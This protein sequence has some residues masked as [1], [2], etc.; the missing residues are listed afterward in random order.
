MSMNDNRENN[1]PKDKIKKRYIKTPLVVALC[2]IVG[3]FGGILGSG[4][5]NQIFLKPSSTNNSSSDSASYKN[6]NSST[7]L[8]SAQVVKLVAD[9]VVDIATESP[10]KTS[11]NKSYVSISAGSGVIYSSDGYIITNEHIVSNNK[12][13]VTLRNGTSYSATLIGSDSNNDIA[14][15][16]I[17]ANNLSAVTFG[18]SSSIEVGEE[19]TVIGNPL[20]ELGGT[21]T[22]GVVSAINR[23][24]EIDGRQMSLIQTS[25]EINSGNSGGGV[26]RRTGE[27]IGI[28][29]A[30]SSG[31]DIEG[32]GF[33]IPSNT[34]KTVVKN[35]LK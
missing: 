32:L 3:I 27:L 1:S 35:L 2:L 5:Y 11:G 15:L 24:V 28:V 10:A 7:L 8:S 29:I 14:L 23:P 30:K 31:N 17:N 20:G 34:V 9:S 12:I 21:V 33:A 18:D 19:T 4:L 26:F 13:T 16:K 6:I 22:D 25:A